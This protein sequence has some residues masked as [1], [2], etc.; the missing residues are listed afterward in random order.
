MIGYNLVLKCMQNIF[1]QQKKKLYSIEK[2]HKP[3]ISVYNNFEQMLGVQNQQS[4]NNKEFY[5]ITTCQFITLIQMPQRDLLQSMLNQFCSLNQT[6][7]IE[8]GVNDYITELAKIVCMLKD[9]YKT[10]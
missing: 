10:N 7:I 8:H 5:F 2:C 6:K 4:N 9:R 1:N 3:F